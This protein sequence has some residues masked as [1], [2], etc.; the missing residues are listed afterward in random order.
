LVWFS[1]HQ[2]IVHA[3]PRSVHWLKQIEVIFYRQ[4]TIQRKSHTL[5][6]DSIYEAFVT[7]SLVFAATAAAHGQ[8][9]CFDT[10]MN[11]NLVG[12]HFYQTL[13]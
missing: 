10:A 4:F 2:R 12:Q 6:K 13:N 1:N 7:A 11:L 9:A 3:N 5:M 8:S